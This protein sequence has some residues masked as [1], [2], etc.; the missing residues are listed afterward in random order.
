MELHG[1]GRG[2]LHRV[3][4]L[5]LH[6][7]EARHRA[8]KGR[9]GGQEKSN[10]AVQ[11]SLFHFTFI[12]FAF[13]LTKAQSWWPSSTQKLREPF[14]NPSPCTSLNWSPFWHSFG[15]EFSP[16]VK[17][18]WAPWQLFAPPSRRWLGLLVWIQ[19]TI[20]H[21][22]F[23]GEEL[24]TLTSNPNHWVGPWSRDVG[25]SANCSCLCR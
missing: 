7:R 12:I 9:Q 10:R 24:P 1:V 20:F 13:F 21:I 17:F 8:R 18:S 22:A 19:W 5:R 16:V 3:C 6:A 2:R 15:R 23:S 11:W 4:A 25:K 14:S